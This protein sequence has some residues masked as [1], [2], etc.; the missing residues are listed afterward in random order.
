MVTQFTTHLTFAIYMDITV[1]RHTIQNA[2]QYQNL[3]HPLFNPITVFNIHNNSH[4]STLITN[5]HTYY[6]YVS[7]SLRPPLRS[8]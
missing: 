2:C 3:P 6:Y 4:F 1:W 7:L 8:A 5:N